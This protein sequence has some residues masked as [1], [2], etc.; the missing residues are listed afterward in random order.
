MT[1]DAVGSVTASGNKFYLNSATFGYTEIFAGPSY[2]TGTFNNNTY[3]NATGK[4]YFGRSGVG[5]VS[6]ATWKSAT[7]YD[8]ASTTTGAAP[9]DSVTIIPNEYE[10]GRAHI[11]IYAPSNPSSIDVDLSTTGLVHGQAY[12]IKNAFDY[13]GV[14]VTSGT[15][16]SGSPTIS[17]SI[18]SGSIARNVATPLGMGATAATT[19]PEFTAMVVVPVNAPTSQMSGTVKL[20]G[21]VTV[22]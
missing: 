10:T 14:A 19:L 2:P 9:S 17:I 13:N 18:G 5:Y 4:D 6:F 8:A 3:Y 16:D 15:Y 20:S 12:T 21:T 1:M 22:R 7:G 11:V